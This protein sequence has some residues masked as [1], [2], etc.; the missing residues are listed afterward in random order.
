MPVNPR[1]QSVIADLNKEKSNALLDRAQ[2]A[3]SRGD[4]DAARAA[5]AASDKISPMNGRAIGIEGQ[6]ARVESRAA[7]GRG[8]SAA[9]IA[10]RA[11]I[12]QQVAKGRAQYLV[13]DID[14]AQGTFRAIEAQDPDNTV[15]KGFLLRI[16]EE[17]TETGALNREK[18]RALLL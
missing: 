17:K 7:G 5:L 6:I 13:G 3:V 8:G 12:A 10:E 1:T 4:L 11:S 18:T 9:F 15:A 14:G 2:A 16:A